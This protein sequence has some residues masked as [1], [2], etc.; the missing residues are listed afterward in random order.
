MLIWGNTKLMINPW[1]W[2]LCLKNPG[3]ATGWDCLIERKG[4]R[5]NL[6]QWQIYIVKFW[7]LPPPPPP[8]P[9]FFIFMQFSAKFG[10]IVDWCPFRAGAPISEILNTPLCFKVYVSLAD[11]GFPR[12]WSENE[13]L[14]FNKVI[15]E[16]CMKMKEIGLGMVRRWPPLDLPMGLNIAKV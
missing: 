1:D 8:G 10:Q 9:I 4:G 11:Q 12:F 5:W 6:F 16:N 13:N 2:Y 14:L 15:P 7:M 3:S